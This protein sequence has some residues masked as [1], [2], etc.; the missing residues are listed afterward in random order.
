MDIF[1]PIPEEGA[2]VDV[3]KYGESWKD[4]NEV[5]VLWY[6][7]RDVHT[8]VLRFKKGIAKFRGENVKIQ[9]W[10]GA[11]P[12]FKERAG[13]GFSGWAPIDDLYNGQWTDGKFDLEVHENSFVFRFRPVNEEFPELGNYDVNY[14][15]TLKVRVILPQDTRGSGERQ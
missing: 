13:S 2:F 9:Y 15:R 5:G 12:R 7:P 11:W 8:I 14:R 1:S 10:E 4:Q 6:D 3:A